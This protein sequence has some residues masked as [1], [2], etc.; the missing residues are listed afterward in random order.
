MKRKR[1]QEQ[2]MAILKEHE[3]ARKFCRDLNWFAG[4]EDTPSRIES[5]RAL[6]NH[7]RPHRSFDK[8]TACSVRSGSSLICSISNIKCCPNSRA[9]HAPRKMQGLLLHSLTNASL[10]G[11]AP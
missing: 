5:W 3:V 1:A 9:R 4:L 7:V 2:T 10:I 6:Y 11:P 8:K